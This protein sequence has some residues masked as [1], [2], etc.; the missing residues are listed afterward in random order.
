MIGGVTMISSNKYLPFAVVLTLAVAAGTASA[1]SGP[2]EGCGAEARLTI[3]FSGWTILDRQPL[4]AEAIRRRPSVILTVG[5]PVIV[6]RYRQLLDLKNLSKVQAD[7]RQGAR[8]VVDEIC[9]GLVSHTYYA[10]AT[11][12][13]DPDTN[14]TRP[15]D[16]ELKD[17]FE[18]LLVP[19]QSASGKR[20]SP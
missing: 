4:D 11:Q 17:F 8:L 1:S 16:A 7:P 3:Y 6:E 19:G 20:A 14:R 2:A 9:G 18:R 10:T 5:N 12:V 13:V 15:L